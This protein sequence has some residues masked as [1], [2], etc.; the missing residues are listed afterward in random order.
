[1]KRR[2]WAWLAHG[3]NN[4]TMQQTLPPER[5][6]AYLREVVDT[7]SGATGQKIHGWLGPGLSESFETPK[8]LHELGLSY[9]LDWTADDQP[10]ALNIP[11]MLSVPYSVELNDVNL[12]LTNAQTGEQF[13]QT[14]VDQLDRLYIEGER[15]GRVMTLALH[16]FVSG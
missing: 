10:F 14:I 16:P 11:G 13:V 15:S 6:R 3:K 12:F 4:S 8:L 7:I 2:N 5:E 9:V 1:G